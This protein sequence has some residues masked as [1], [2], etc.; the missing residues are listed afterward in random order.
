MTLTQ[1]PDVRPHWLRKTI[2]IIVLPLVIFAYLYLMI[3]DSLPTVIEDMR[4]A[5]NG[6]NH[7]A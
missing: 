5:W 3:A 2:F 1:L 7:D 4:Y 6:G